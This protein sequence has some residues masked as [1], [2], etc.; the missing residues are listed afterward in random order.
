MKRRIVL[1]RHAMPDIPLGERWC[2]G[3]RS[4]FPLGRLGRIQA[5]RLPFTEE[6]EGLR[7]VFASPLVRAIETARPLCAA[8]RIMPGR[9]EQDMGVWDGLPFHEIMARWPEL[10]AARERD[11]S[12]LPEG[13]ESGEAVAARMRGAILRCL[14]ESEGDLALVSHKSAIAA[15]TGERGRLG[16]TTLTVLEEENSALRVRVIGLSPQPEL[17]DELCLAMLRA[18]GADEALIAHSRAVAALADGL[19]AGLKEKGIALDSGAVHAAALLHDIAKG[20]PD[21]A[22]VGGLWLRELAY[23]ELAEIVRQHTEP[24]CGALNEAGLVFLADKLVRGAARVELEE[25]FGASLAKCKTPEALAAHA[26]RRAC[27]EAIREQII[28]L[29]GAELLKQEAIP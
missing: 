6:L 5:A 13:A 19:C 17:T 29:C 8:P 25:R 11:P 24:D 20:E 27:A 15:I 10:Y 3:G 21:H 22:A 28:R 16:Y 1:I 18:S 26:R 4:D 12:L 7:T 23:P 14:R 9:E 2:V